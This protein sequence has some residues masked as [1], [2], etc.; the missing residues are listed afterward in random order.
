MSDTE[1]KSFCDKMVE[2]AAE[3]MEAAGA[4]LGMIVDR[5]VTYGVAQMVAADGS[6]ITSRNLHMI[7]EKIGAGAFAQVSGENAQRS[8]VRH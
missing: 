5:L 6:E 2:V 7:A 4:P 8:G 1:M 3:G